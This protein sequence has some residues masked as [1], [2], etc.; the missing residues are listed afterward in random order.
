MQRL[1]ILKNFNGAMEILTALNLNAVT[2]ALEPEWKSVPSK[3]VE[4][5]KEISDL[6]DPKYI[7]LNISEFFCFVIESQY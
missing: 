2:R 4:A 6:L 7:Q 3:Y 1:V 5:L